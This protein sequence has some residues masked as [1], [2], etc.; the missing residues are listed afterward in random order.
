MAKVFIRTTTRARGAAKITGVDLSPGMIELA[1]EQESRHKLGIEYLVGDA[2]NLEE[3]HGRVDLVVAAYLL[4]RKIGK[5]C[6]QCLTAWRGLS[7]VG[8][9]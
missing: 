6:K 3:C 4:R 2:R 5:N 1:R 8:D 9:S 7:W